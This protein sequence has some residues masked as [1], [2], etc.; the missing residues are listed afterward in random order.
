MRTLLKIVSYLFSGLRFRL[1]VLVLLTC[2]P[3]VA[4]TLHTS[5]E[6]RR[7]AMANWRQRSAAFVQ[8]AAGEE[9]KL[10]S[11]GKSLLHALSES[12]AVQSGDVEGCKKLL[13]QFSGGR[14]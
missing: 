8:H 6:D 13:P 11:D 4:L 9:Q 7:K 10:L 1:L 5:W 3:L 2:A 14:Y 12:E